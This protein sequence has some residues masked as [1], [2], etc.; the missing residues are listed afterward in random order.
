LNPLLRCL[1]TSIEAFPR[2][3]AITAPFPPPAAVIEATV[4]K[5]FAEV[6][7]GGLPEKTQ[8]T[9]TWTTILGRKTKQQQQQNSP[10]TPQKT[11]DPN[12]RHVYLRA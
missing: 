5:S 11:N 2:S 12:E 3:D 7:K 10:F 6:L 4:K 9:G 8:E 1:E